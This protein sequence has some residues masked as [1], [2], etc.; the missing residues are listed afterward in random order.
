MSILV[1]ILVQYTGL[2]VADEIAEIQVLRL[3]YNRFHIYSM[4]IIG[5]KQRSH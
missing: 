3:F 2:V 5:D 4:A 1:D